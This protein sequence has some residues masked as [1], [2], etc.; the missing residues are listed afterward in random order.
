MNTFNFSKYKK[1]K[2]INIYMVFAI[3]ISF[4]FFLFVL[5][6][7]KATSEIDIQ[8]ENGEVSNGTTCV[9]ITPTCSD[10]E[11]LVDNVCTII[12]VNQ[13]EILK[14]VTVYDLTDMYVFDDEELT[15]YTN[16]NDIGIP[17]V[18]I[19]DFNNFLQVALVEFDFVVD[20]QMTLSYQWGNNP[21]TYI[22]NVTID[23]V[24]NTISFSDFSMIHFINDYETNEV[25]NDASQDSNVQSLGGFYIEGNPVVTI[26]LDIYDLE[27]IQEKDVYYVPLY[28]AN[29]FFTGDLLNV[30]VEDDKIYV[31]D[32]PYAFDSIEI[33]LNDDEIDQDVYVKHNASYLALL[34]DYFYGL[35]DYKEIDSFSEKLS[36]YKIDRAQ[37]L[38]YQH[39][40]MQDFV[41]DLDDMHTG[42]ESFGYFADQTTLSSIP[43][44]SKIYEFYSEYINSLC[45]YRTESVSL[46]EY[47]EAY[48][49][50]INNFSYDTA[51]LLKEVLVDLDPEKML[52]IDLTCNTGG[53]LD[54]VLEL[55]S[56]L[57]DDMTIYMEDSLIKTTTTRNYSTINDTILENQVVVIT[58]KVTYSAANLFVSIV[59]DKGLALVIGHKTGG[60]AAAVAFTLLPDYTMLT[61]SSS[62]LLKNKNG[63][64]IED[65]IE[66]DI[67]VG[68]DSYYRRVINSFSSVYNI[69]KEIKVNN[70]ST[71]E[72]FDIEITSKTS[73]IFEFV[74]YKVELYNTE[75]EEILTQNSYY[76][77][78]LHI[79]GSIGLNFADARMQITVVYKI[80]G[81]VIEETIYTGLIDDH[82]DFFDTENTELEVGVEFIAHASYL[83]DIDYFKLDIEQTDTFQISCNG[84]LSSYK[85]ML[86]NEHGYE[87]TF[88][89]FVMLN[90]GTY[91]LRVNPQLANK[92]Y[93][94]LYEPVYDDNKSGTPVTLTTGE[95]IIPLIY[96]YKGD[97]EWLEIEVVNEVLF[98][99]NDYKYLIYIK[100]L[101]GSYYHSDTNVMDS[102]KF[103]C[104]LVPGIYKMGINTK[105]EGIYNFDFTIDEETNEYN[106]DVHHNDQY[107]GQLNIGINEIQF[108]YV[109]DADIYVLEIDQELTIELNF[110]HIMVYVYQN[111]E[112]ILKK[113]NDIL[114]LNQGT[115]Y[116]R[117]IY[118]NIATKSFTINILYDDSTIDNSTLLVLETEVHYELFTN[119]IDYAHFTLNELETVVLVLSGGN[120]GVICLFDSN[121]TLLHKAEAGTMVL[122]IQLLPGTYKI[123]IKLEERFLFYRIKEYS[124][125]LLYNDRGDTNYNLIGLPLDQYQTYDA[126]QNQAITGIHEY[127]DDIDVYIL[128]INTL[129]D[130]QLVGDLTYMS[131][132]LYSLE[133]QYITDWSDQILYLEQGKYFLAIK[134]EDY[135]SHD[136]ELTVEITP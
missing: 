95:Y 21:D 8:C 98:T 104:I 100:N 81:F 131:V 135:Y 24:E 31:F 29:L 35:K 108:E 125:K 89:D 111:D 127:T 117:F 43:K 94:I 41:F 53:N 20:Q 33:E 30:L 38:P 28:L 14:Q 113:N 91:Y 73:D 132:A 97:E 37:S 71:V 12:D 102:S 103:P 50:S 78:N 10:L 105:I 86:F 107:F 54:G 61:Y 39:L 9:P 46:E 18:S 13:M 67:E 52:F 16:P 44:D 119:D 110:D 72:G 124:L 57:T 87:I 2:R 68:I 7:C 126:D 134:N 123:E 60:G 49:L 84:I 15:I 65:G 80:N 122:N 82:L 130:Y 74:K 115:H 90:T 48:V 79:K 92:D 66:P 121:D 55:L 19:E 99:L 22:S 3:S 118:S 59:K 64:I 1:K 120:E 114:V 27:I 34:F 93:T 23:A 129:S 36:K 76:Q 6:S 62:T 77:D 88:E 69:N 47:M 85:L 32:D 75:T 45:E 101:D 17:Y 25:I 136:Y 96:D 63:D 128:N 116:F 56:Y 51:K 83:G 40:R 109:L 5:S 26:D 42:I 106:G 133:G 11:E 4:F 58:S 70:R 112:Y